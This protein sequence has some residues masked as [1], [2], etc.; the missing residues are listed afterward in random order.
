MTP[1]LKFRYTIPTDH[2]V[3]SGLIREDILTA[4][5]QVFGEKGF[6][7]ASM[8]DV[9]KAVELRKASLY[10]HVPSKQAL[11]AAILDQAL[12]ILIARME[13]VMAEPASCGEKLRAALV[14]YQEAMAEYPNL[15]AVLL[16]EHR[17]L[18]AKYRRRHIP[19]RDRFE[20]LWRQLIEEGMQ[21]GDFD[22]ADPNMAAKA[23][24]GVANWTVTWF[25]PNGRLSAKE[26]AEYNADLLLDGLIIRT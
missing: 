25:R 3:G 15:A 8:E 23:I 22:C 12:D 16:L 14:A 20:G 4:A 2:S 7:A 1:A 19:R 17:S 11:L 18:D 9:A 6:H 21:S 13:A 26:I 24:L 5:A 10:H